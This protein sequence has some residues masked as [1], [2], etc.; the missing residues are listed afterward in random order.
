MF[1]DEVPQRPAADAATLGRCRS[2]RDLTSL[3]GLGRARNSNRP[4][5]SFS[6]PFH[7]ENSPGSVDPFHMLRAPEAPSPPPR[8]RPETAQLT[9]DNSHAHWTKN[10]KQTTEFPN[11]QIGGTLT[12]GRSTLPT[13]KWVHV[14]PTLPPPAFFK[15]YPGESKLIMWPRL[16]VFPFPTP[17]SSGKRCRR[18]TR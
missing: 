9:G 3:R 17:S 12:G 5:P 14:N 13:S 6:F 4:C 11:N 8:Q 18:Q 10:W 7:A 2:L 1:R 15:G 16:P